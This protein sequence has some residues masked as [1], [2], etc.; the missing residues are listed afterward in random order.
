MFV[1]KKDYED[2]DGDHH[3]HNGGELKINYYCCVLRWHNSAIKN[4]NIN[5]QCIH[6]HIVGIINV[7]KLCK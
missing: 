3:V 1:K 5:I 6:V 7:N 4:Y 2:D